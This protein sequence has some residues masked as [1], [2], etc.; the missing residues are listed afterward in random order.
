MHVGSQRSLHI[1]KSPG[2]S[3]FIRLTEEDCEKADCSW[4]FVAVRGCSWLSVSW[5]F[6]FRVSGSRFSAGTLWRVAYPA[7]QPL[8]ENAFFY[9]RARGLYSG[10]GFYLGSGKAAFLG[11]GQDPSLTWSI[12]RFRACPWQNWSFKF[13]FHVSGS[14]FSAD[15]LWKVA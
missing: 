15:T 4:L 14:W 11:Q 8:R 2:P 13:G 1:R 3:D 10:R 5:V 6:V 9:R 7:A 12:Q